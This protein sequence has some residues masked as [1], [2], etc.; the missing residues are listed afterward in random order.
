M[1]YAWKKHVMHLDTN[2]PLESNGPSPVTQPLSLL[3]SSNAGVGLQPSL[4]SYTRTKNFRSVSC[5]QN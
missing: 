3:C 4:H 2:P 1:N 5:W